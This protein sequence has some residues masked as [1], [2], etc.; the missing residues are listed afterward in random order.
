[1]SALQRQK[2]MNEPIVGVNDVRFEVR[3][4]LMEAEREFRIWKRWCVFASSIA[5]QSGAALNRA[6][7]SPNFDPLVQQIFFKAVLPH[8]RNPNRMTALRS[9]R[10]SLRTWRSSPPMI[11]E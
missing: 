4:N 8:R 11:G 9:A 6:T 10:L 2:G 1:G 3:R 7:Q 5:E